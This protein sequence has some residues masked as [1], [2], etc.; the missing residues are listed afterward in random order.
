[1]KHGAPKYATKRDESLPTLGPV[2]GEVS[3]LVRGKK[4]MPWQQYVA[5]VA[6]ELSR[7]H[8]GEFRYETVIVTVPRQAGKSDLVGAIHTHRLMAYRDHHA[9]MTAQTGKDAGKRWRSIVDNIDDSAGKRM[10]VNRGKGSE[11]LTWLP[12]R[13]DLSPFAP[14]VDSIHGDALN[15]A[16]IDEAW[17]FTQAQGADLETAIKPTFLTIANSQ[18]WIVST[19]GTANSQWLNEKIAIGREAVNDPKS[20]V[21]FFEWSADEEAADADPYS[22]ATL[23]FHPAIGY[24]QTARKIR[25][26]G[27]GKDT[28]LGEWRR[29]YLNLPTSTNETAIDLAVWDS[30]KWNYDSEE[31]ERDRPTRPED[32]VLAWDVSLDG[33]NASIAAAWIDTEG[34]PAVEIIATAPGTAW[35]RDALRRAAARGYRS[36]ISDDTGPNRTIHLDLTDVPMKICGWDTYGSACQALIDRVREGTIT[37]DGNPVLRAA[38]EVAVLR[39]SAKVQVFDAAKSAGA[40]DALRAVTLAQY[41]ASKALLAP[42]VPIF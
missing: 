33:Q 11:L 2:V 21:A 24:T 6:C 23:S 26:L 41:E 12:T 35:V 22:D 18:L 4:L 8:P 5:N 27:G 16:S 9:V 20:R 42:V 32:Y 36:I 19:R 39:Q 28:S 17:A 7:E 14:T 15:L 10:K 1:M 31:T 13:S 3:R 25:D 30:L 37:H 38:M 34:N 29:S 40:I